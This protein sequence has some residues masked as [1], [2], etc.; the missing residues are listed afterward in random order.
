MGPVGFRRPGSKGP[1]GDPDPG[2]WTLRG[3]GRIVK[4]KHRP[5]R[6]AVI[7]KQTPVAEA[8]RLGT[9]GRVVRDGSA[10]E[11]S[12]YCRRAVSKAV[13]LAGFAAG[14]AVTLFSLGPPAADA[15]LREGI[16]WGLDRDVDIRGTLLTDV[17][18]AGSDTFATAT[19]LS[20][21][22]AREGPFDLILAG[23]NSIDSDTGQVPPQVAEMLGLPFASGV[24]ELLLRGNVLQ[25]GCEH[26]D[27]WVEM[28]MDL[29]AL[30]SCAER[31]CEPTK[32]SSDR[33]HS[34]SGDRV[35]TLTSKDLGDG[36]WGTAGSLTKVG[37]CRTTSIER[38]QVVSPEAPLRAQ[39]NEAVQFLLH[40]GALQPGV[41]H[42]IG[43]MP[44]TGGSGSVVAVVAEPH[45]DIITQELCSLSARL[46]SELGGSTLLFSS[47][48]VSESN[49]GSWGADHLVR[50]DGGESNEDFS[51][52]VSSWAIEDP[53]WAILS[54]STAYGR[55]VASRVAAT[56]K[57]GLTGDAVDLDVVDG[58]L[59]AWKPAFGGQLV[60]AIETTSTVQMATTRA[61]VVRAFA[62]RDHIARLST[63]TAEARGRAR[64]HDRRQLDSPVGLTEAEV[65]L[66]V[67]QGVGPDELHHLDELQQMLGA[68]MGCTR[69]MTDAG[70][71]PH[72]RQI[73]ITGRSISPRLYV[74]I[75]TSGKF[76]HM[77]GVRSAR[78]VLAI[79]RDPDAPVFMHA[80]V[81]IV[82]TFQE[83]LP[84][85][86][87]ALRQAL[88]SSTHP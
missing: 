48:G 44:L 55:E 88:T 64:T 47:P 26:D 58:R 21:A 31:L 3:F 16:A 59:V 83:C 86:V 34:V 66:G 45:E 74:A 80:D 56:I 82:A 69:K 19:A 33:W 42:Q 73:G 5:M 6:I 53:P 63:R 38:T 62:P 67:G 13:E 37:V 87:D 40:R 8:L 28:T 2:L 78:T 20:A 29:P 24:R 68:E 14:S 7:V 15:V 49:A 84:L 72:G 79:N 71:M 50:I 46:A 39:V 60:A 75:G 17:A 10:L 18:F 32:I 76:N 11:M 65:V 1:T 85:L 54:G 51:R 61:G 35:R 41:S 77:V 43:P 22:I 36:P 52:A 81:G 25:L 57:A 27:S 23:K 9:D 12:A 4:G 70:R 30:L